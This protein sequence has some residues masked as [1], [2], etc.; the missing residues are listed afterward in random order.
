M[1]KYIVYSIMGFLVLFACISCD[2]LEQGEPGAVIQCI[3]CRS[4]QNVVVLDTCARLDTL[5]QIAKRRHYTN[6]IYRGE[7]TSLKHTNI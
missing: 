4:S 2:K 5:N 3:E 1:K 6:C 7:H